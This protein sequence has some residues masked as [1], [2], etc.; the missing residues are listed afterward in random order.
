MY[1]IIEKG[2]KVACFSVHPGC[3]M[4]EVTRNMKWWMQLGDKLATPIMMTLRKTPQ[5]GAYSSLYA[6][7]DPVIYEDRS[8]WGKLLFHCKV[9][10][11]ENPAGSDKDAAKRLWELSERLT[12]LK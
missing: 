4:T 9:F 1:R 8:K 2:S 5:E 10:N 7:T 3:V 12:G 6:A 11:R